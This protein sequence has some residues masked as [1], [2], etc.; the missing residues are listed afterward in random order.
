VYFVF[1]VVKF[2]ENSWIPGHLTIAPRTN[3][4][5]GISSWPF[6]TG[7]VFRNDQIAM[8]LWP[9]QDAAGASAGRDNSEICGL[10]PQGLSRR[11]FAC[12]LSNG[13]IP[14][15]LLKTLVSSAQ[16]RSN[17]GQMQVTG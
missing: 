13:D 1:F 16:P 10:S 15:S 9:E 3:E 4:G 7:R 11:G 8:R 2:P 5:M 6:C 14:G 12:A 17:S